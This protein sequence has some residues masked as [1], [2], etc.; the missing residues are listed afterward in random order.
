MKKAIV[1]LVVG[2]T[3]R[4]IYDHIAPLNRMWMGRLGWE[5]I[6][7]D[8][9][10]EDFRKRYDRKSKANGWIYY[11]YKLFLPSILLNYDLIAFV[12]SDCVINPN[13]ECLSQYV[14]KIPLG[15]FAGVQTVTFEERKLFPTWK[16]FYYDALRDIG[17][18]GLPPYPER[19]INAGLLL[20]R[21]KDIWKR[22]IELLNIETN[23]NEENR[24]NVYEVQDNRCFFLPR[25][26]NTVWLY[27]RVIRGWSPGFHRNKLFRKIHESVLTLSEGRKIN[28]VYKNVAMLHFAF[29][30]QKMLLIDSNSF[31]A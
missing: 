20:Y 27:E 11:M 26:W 28:M 2:D 5:E 17:Y 24:L 12:D 29:E 10:P 25:M 7:I 9:I 4:K 8:C 30:H 21:P 31:N 23:L 14:D 16:C 13:A 15:G 3:Y 6:I 18:D 1:T 22:W 19:H